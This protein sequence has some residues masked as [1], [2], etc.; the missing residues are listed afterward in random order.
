MRGS[1]RNDFARPSRPPPHG[2]NVSY[3]CRRA[4]LP[5]AASTAGTAGARAPVIVA[6]CPPLDRRGAD[7]GPRGVVPLGLR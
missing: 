6:A 3:A 1:I 5:P 7:D 4:G 2:H